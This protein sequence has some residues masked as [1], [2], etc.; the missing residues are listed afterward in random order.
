MQNIKLLLF[1]LFYFIQIECQFKYRYNSFYKE[2]KH[3]PIMDRLQR[4]INEIQSNW[5]KRI[6]SRHR[7]RSIQS[8]L[9]NGDLNNDVEIAFPSAYQTTEDLVRKEGYPVEAHNVTTED[10]YILT[11]HRIPGTPSNPLP[12]GKPVVMVQHGILCS[13]TDWVIAGPNKSLGYIL[14]DQGF[15]VWLGNARGNTYSRKHMLYNPENHTKI[16]WDFSWH[17]MGIYDL[18]VVIDYILSVTGQPKLSYIGHSMGTTMFWVLLSEKPEYNDK[19][20]VMIAMAPIAFINHVKSPVIRFLATISDPLAFLINSLGFY[21]FLP[22][23]KFLVLVDQMLCQRGS[24]IQ[25]I[26]DNVL[27]LIAG[28]DSEQLNKTVLPLI[29]A[30]TPAGAS[31]KQLTH[32]SQL[33]KM[34]RTF[35]QYD[36][37]WL[38][39]WRK[40]GQLRPPSYRLSNVKVPVALFYSN[41]DWLAPGEDVDVLS[42]KLPNVVGK[43]KV[44]LKR[45]NHL[46]FMWAIDVKKLL[47]DDVVRVLHKYNR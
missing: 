32:Y 6:E 46:D 39:N 13:S 3:V 14:A 16:F 44:P 22:N 29:L 5:Q 9:I 12:Y 7:Q 10:G 42:R 19:I 28:Y 41:N 40:Y 31:S 21:E 30:H 34:D 25:G 11:L 33:M 47:Y 35:Q 2:P 8:N 43:Y 27:F 45:F 38:G 1:G 26:C 4:R 24:L 17:E 23:N 20:E 18:P 15:D 37:G 36:L